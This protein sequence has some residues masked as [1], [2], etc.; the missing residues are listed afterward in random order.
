VIVIPYLYFPAET[1]PAGTEIEL[2][3]EFPSVEE[4]Y[5]CVRHR[6]VAATT[7]ENTLYKVVDEAPSGAQIQLVTPKSFKLGADTTP[8]DIY[9]IVFM[10]DHILRGGRL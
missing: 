7:F 1:I 10:V 3:E 2:P 8:G 5:V 9:E 6:L 4:I